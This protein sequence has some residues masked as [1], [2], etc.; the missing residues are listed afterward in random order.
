[1]KDDA[2]ETQLEHPPE[3]GGAPESEQRLFQ[4]VQAGAVAYQRP[5]G[6]SSIGS[7]GA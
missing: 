5:G 7:L 6:G 2:D 3:S 1:M 4:I